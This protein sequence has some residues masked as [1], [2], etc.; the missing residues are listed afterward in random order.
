[1]RKTIF[2]RRIVLLVF[3]V[4]CLPVTFLPVL[5][6]LFKKDF[7]PFFVVDQNINYFGW[8]FRKDYLFDFFIINIVISGYFLRNIVHL[9]IQLLRDYRFLKKDERTH[10][11]YLRNRTWE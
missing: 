11:Y 7:A 8:L 10:L 2:Q 5:E 9:I 6:I 3:F 1:M 4:I